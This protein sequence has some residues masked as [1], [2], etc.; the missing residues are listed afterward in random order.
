[1]TE[2]AVGIEGQTD[3]LS[4]LHARK[5]AL[6]AK[7]DRIITETESVRI[8]RE[9]ATIDA[10]M[11]EVKSDPVIGGLFHT[12]KLIAMLETTKDK[13]KVRRSLR[14]QISLLVEWIDVE[15][16][17]YRKR[18]S[19]KMCDITV[20]FVNREKRYLYMRANGRTLE[21]SGL[22]LLKGDTATGRQTSSDEYGEPKIPVHL[23]P[24]SE[25][26]QG[27]SEKAPA[28]GKSVERFYAARGIRIEDVQLDPNMKAL[29]MFMDKIEPEL[30]Q[31]GLKKNGK[32]TKN[33]EKKLKEDEERDQKAIRNWVRRNME[34]TGRLKNGKLTE[35][36]EAEKGLTAEGR[37]K[38]LE[39]GLV[40]DGKPTEKARAEFNEVT[41]A[42]LTV[43]L[44]L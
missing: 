26:C 27:D 16:P 18:L 20:T 29:L 24:P 14:Q 37:A 9:L 3:K 6:E 40:K 43:L 39:D 25:R 5:E 8:R 7:R 4:A 22:L 36:G 15:V 10:E 42:L 2:A 1:M 11:K 23:S 34:A 30:E 19:V 41:Q 32:I 21:E 35:K 13:E 17:G 44:D 28:T 38:L 31:K 33:G 12:E